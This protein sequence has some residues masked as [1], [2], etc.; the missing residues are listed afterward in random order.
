MSLLN[1]WPSKD[2]VNRCIHPVAEAAHEAVLLA[3]HQPSSLSFRVLPDGAKQTATEDDLYAYF[4]SDDVSTG[5]HVVPITGASG[6]GKSHLVRILEVR[7]H[8][9][10]DADRY[11]IIRIPKTASLREVVR[12]IL[13]PLPDEKY[14]EVKAAFSKALAEVRIETAVID[15]QAKLEIALENLAKKLK[16]KLE[17]G[18]NP[19][20]TEQM[21]HA[22]AL[23]KFM[24]DPEVADHFR[25]TVFPK[26]VTRALAGQ[27]T[28]VEAGAAEDFSE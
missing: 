17:E 6:V 23:P 7:L 27:G 20:L 13:A 28:E 4:T 10:A 18:R 16:A 8:A 1:Y 21:A 19:V 15:F 11:L 5:V 22:S 24:R 12:L 3:V 9:A 26:I 2:E 25:A 14:S